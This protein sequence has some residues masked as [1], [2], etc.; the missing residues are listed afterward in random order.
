MPEGGGEVVEEL[1]QIGMVPLVPLAGVDGYVSAGR[2]EAERRRSW[3]LTRAV[4]N[5]TQVRENRIGW[6]DELQGV[7]VVL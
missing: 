6:V 3:E 4:G 2:Q 5:S 1:L 7:T